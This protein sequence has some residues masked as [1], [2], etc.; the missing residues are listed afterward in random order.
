MA[1]SL[2]VRHHFAFVL[3]QPL[4]EPTS[5][6]SVQYFKV[7]AGLHYLPQLLKSNELTIAFS[8]HHKLPQTITRPSTPKVPAGL[9]KIHQ[10]FK[11]KYDTTF[12][13]KPT[14]STGY[15]GVHSSKGA[16]WSCTAFA[17]SSN[18]NSTTYPSLT[19]QR[20]PQ[21][22]STHVVCLIPALPNHVPQNHQLPPRPPRLHAYL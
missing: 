16:S 14:N 18:P 4:S 7:P 1:I 9:R 13:L 10:L 5:Y 6:N 22:I 12:C 17:N 8:N 2:I 21:E 20:T 19:H 15:S 3:S 11:S